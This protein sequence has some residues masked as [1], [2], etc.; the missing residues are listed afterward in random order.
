MD[1]INNSTYFFHANS[2]TILSFCNLIAFIG[3][4]DLNTDFY[5][6]RPDIIC[7]K[8]IRGIIL[9]SIIHM[10]IKSI[11]YTV[12]VFFIYQILIDDY[13]FTKCNINNTNNTNHTHTDNTNHTHTDIPLPTTVCTS[14]K[15]F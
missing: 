12:I 4:R 2:D 14:S 7:N 9:F 15:C 5:E 3:A 13:I 1:F 8:F 10:N 11:K 6:R